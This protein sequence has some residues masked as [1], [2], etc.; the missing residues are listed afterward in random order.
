MK[1]SLNFEIGSMEINGTEFNNIKCQFDSSMN[2]DE[3]AVVSTDTYQKTI[4]LFELM[5]LI[6]QQSE[7]K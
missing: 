4:E 1:F 2:S 3:Y 5:G 7:E 6:P